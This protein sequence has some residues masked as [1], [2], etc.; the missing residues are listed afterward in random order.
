MF[1]FFFEFRVKVSHLRVTCS[2]FHKDTATR[3]PSRKFVKLKLETCRVHRRCRLK[4]IFSIDLWSSRRIKCCLFELLW[5]I[6]WHVQ[7]TISFL[8]CWPGAKRS[9]PRWTPRTRARS[10]PG[11]STSTG[12]WTARTGPVWS[13]WWAWRWASWRGP[14]RLSWPA[15]AR[16][17]SPSTANGASPSACSRRSSGP[18]SWSSPASRRPCAAGAVGEEWP[19][20]KRMYA[21]EQACQVFAISYDWNDL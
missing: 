2:T 3:A 10:S 20:R 12:S 8:G 7:D 15:P 16:A 13:P 21:T 18:G 17:W 9:R 5:L 19:D 1:F 4:Y 6:F 14:W 11:P